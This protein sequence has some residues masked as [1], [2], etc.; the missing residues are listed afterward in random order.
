MSTV[1]SRQIG[2]VRNVR[3]GQ[4]RRTGSISGRRVGLLLPFDPLQRGR[5]EINRPSGADGFLNSL[6]SKRTETGCST[7][8]VIY[9]NS[10]RVSGPFRAETKPKNP[11]I[12][13]AGTR[14]GYAIDFASDAQWVNRMVLARSTLRL[15][16]ISW[17]REPAHGAQSF[18]LASAF[19]SAFRLAC[20]ARK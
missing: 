10:R 6:S 18:S 19:G 4:P 5:K 9:S 20:G 11:K 2:V 8:Q 13:P 12:D 3:A 1:Y 17:R 15:S 16:E 7:V 14:H